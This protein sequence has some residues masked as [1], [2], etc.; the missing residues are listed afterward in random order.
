M[1]KTIKNWFTVKKLFPQVWGIA[2]FA[3]NEKVI[4]YLFVGKHKALLF[5]SGMGIEDISQEVKKI[6]DLEVVLINS[7]FH[8]DHVGG[9]SLFEHKKITKKDEIIRLSPF[10]F[11]IIH[12]PGHTAD[13][14]CLFEKKTNI[15]LT[16]DTFYPGPIYLQLKESSLLE[17]K[18]SIKKLLKFVKGG[19]ILPGHN[20]FVSKYSLLKEL[21]IFLENN[22]INLNQEEIKI[23]KKLSLKL[24]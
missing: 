20:A 7:H 2:E 18:K 12:S 14:I 23:T 5:D 10:K 16:G 1:G 8:Y 13:S 17:Y 19:I 15:L 4:S 22:D 9:N 11:D 6:T 3:H 21:G 24:K